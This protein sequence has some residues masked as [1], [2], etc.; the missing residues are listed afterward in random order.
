MAA[1]IIQ[2]P[3]KPAPTVPAPAPEKPPKRK[4]GASQKEDQRKSMLA[5]VHIAKAELMRKLPNFNDDTYR[6]ILEQLFGVSSS[7]DLDNGQLHNL[8]IHFADLGF[9]AKK[10]RHKRPDTDE[11]GLEAKM[12][13]I[14]ALLAEKGRAEG[15]DVPWGYAVT[16]LKNQTRGKINNFNSP[17]LTAADLKGVIAAL[18]KDA[19]RRGRYYEVY[20]RA[21]NKR[22]AP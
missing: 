2:F 10:G 22:R 21:E 1:I 11:P 7:K 5:K 13:K 12:E 19:K 9:K 6:F 18:T 8:L 3:R 16:I 20:G 15:T 14:E 4:R 17:E